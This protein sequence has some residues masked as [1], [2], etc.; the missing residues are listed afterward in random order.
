MTNEPQASLN[1]NAPKEVNSAIEFYKIRERSTPVSCNTVQLTAYNT[2]YCG[3]RLSTY[4]VCCG[5]VSYLNSI[6]VSWG[7]NTRVLLFCPN[8]ES[9]RTT[10]LY[11]RTRE[12][13]TFEE[14]ERSKLK[15]TDEM[16]PT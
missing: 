14:V 15:A 13:L 10:K 3:V 11:D 9:P 4:T 5:R 8:L 2:T 16:N 6:A 12:E 7:N 1:T